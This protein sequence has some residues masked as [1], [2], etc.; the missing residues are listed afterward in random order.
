MSENNLGSINDYLFDQLRRLSD[1]NKKGEE[2]KEEMER[3]NAVTKVAGSIIGNANL[4][5]QAQKF[6][7]DKWNAD[8]KTPKMLEG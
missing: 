4:V 6:T 7:D 3:A 5:L 2:L 1:E 8:A